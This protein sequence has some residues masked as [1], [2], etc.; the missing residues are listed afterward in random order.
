MSKTK[1]SLILGSGFSKVAG[2][3][4]TNEIVDHFLI[5]PA[6]SNRDRQIEEWISEIL[7]EFWRD[8]FGYKA[9]GVKPSL[10]DHFTVIDL[11]ANSGH[12]L[13]RNY[14][15]KKLRAVRRM[16]IHRIFRIL[17]QRYQ[18]SEEICQLLNSLNECFD[19]SI[20][21]LN[22][23][24]V[25]E[26]HLQKLNIPF[27]YEINVFDFSCTQLKH[28]GLSLLKMHGSSNWLYCD[29][30]RRIFT[31]ITEKSAL[32]R[33]VFLEVEDF[34]EFGFIN[35][36]PD[37]I[38]DEDRICCNCIN[39]LA[40]RV[41]TFSYRKAFSIAQFQTIWDRAHAVLSDAN[42]WLFVGYSLP[43]A[44]FE[45]THLL[46]SAQLGRNNPSD[47]SAEVITK[48]DQEAETRFKR[49][50]GADKTNVDCTGLV[51]WVD[52]R[53]EKYIEGLCR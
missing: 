53:L 12:H 50:F 25:V 38:I 26:K 6:A 30:C 11:A 52:K 8:V 36:I 27:Y 45:F 41:A 49:F 21:S 3:P 7:T 10:E 5:T 22:W 44:D 39:K 51:S 35:V 19:L 1:L 4:T 46:K 24:I 48:D 18:E 20:V 17:D 28:E 40:G 32:Y 47:W 29:S 37:I 43:E 33:K 15:P 2:L 14:S 42:K 31:D 34:Q 13:G 16:S 23:D 9:G